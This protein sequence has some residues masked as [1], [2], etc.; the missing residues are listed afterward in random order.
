MNMVAVRNLLSSLNSLGLHPGGWREGDRVTTLAAA[1]GGLPEPGEGPYAEGGV[2]P[3]LDEV[4]DDPVIHLVMRAD[5]LEPE[6][7]RRLLTSGQ[8]RAEP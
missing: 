7:V 3:P 8:W 2:E 5:H 1:R 4:L 6:Q